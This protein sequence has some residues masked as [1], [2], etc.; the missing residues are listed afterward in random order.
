MHVFHR[1]P[2]N[3]VFYCAAGLK[4]GVPSEDVDILLSAAHRMGLDVVG[5]AFH[6]GCGSADA[7]AF[8][9]AISSAKAASQ[10]FPKYGFHMQT[11]DIGGGFPGIVDYANTDHL[12]YR[13]AR[14]V[15]QS[16]ERD[17][18]HKDFPQ[19][20]IISEP[21]QYFVASAFR[22]LTKVVGKRVIETDNG[23][24]YMYYL[25]D[26]LFG[27]CRICCLMIQQK[28]ALSLFF[29]SLSMIGTFLIKLWEPERIKLKPLL[30]DSVLETRNSFPSTFWGPTCDSSDLVARRIQMKELH[31]DEYLVTE[32][33]GAYTVPLTT[34]F[35]GM[36]KPV[37][38]FFSSDGRN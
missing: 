4:F 24:E 17:F 23:K 14:V 11:L 29:F 38:H 28:C 32:Q 8:D 7:N 22:L 25:N 31:I 9:T 34:P 13:M 5:V 10:L 20:R 30:P 35:N 1:K 19:L 15:K 33:F 3:K 37:F 26:G 18:S 21:G 27:W 36:E 12:F 6:V 2:S 16:L